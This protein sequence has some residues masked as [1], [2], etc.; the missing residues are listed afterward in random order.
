MREGQNDINYFQL[1]SYKSPGAQ[2]TGSKI[3]CISSGGG[4][5]ALA[6]TRFK[7]YETK[8]TSFVRE[9]NIHSAESGSPVH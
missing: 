7:C 3:K 5:I 9:F 4:W 8:T 6:L 2:N 1:R